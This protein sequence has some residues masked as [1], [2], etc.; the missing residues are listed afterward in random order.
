MTLLKLRAPAPQYL[1]G[2]LFEVGSRNY[3]RVGA[4]GTVLVDTEMVS[5]SAFPAGFE[6]VEA[7][8][9]LTKFIA[10]A[11]CTPGSLFADSLGNIHLVLR[12]GTAIVDMAAVN[13]GQLIAQGFQGLTSR[14]SS[15]QRPAMAVPGQLFYDETLGMELRRSASNDAWLCPSGAR[16]GD[17]APPP[18]EAQPC[19]VQ[20]EPAAAVSAPEVEQPT[21]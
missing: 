7:P 3:H 18:A 20:Q 19:E 4:D 21:A 16:V 2:T 15:A 17:V 10:P 9:T 5:L 1:P 14:G 13:I 8:G 6:P 12:D 11:H